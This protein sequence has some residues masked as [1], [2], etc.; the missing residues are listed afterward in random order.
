M[1]IISLA[2]KLLNPAASMYVNTSRNPMVLFQ[3]TSV[4]HIKVV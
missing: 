3:N 2:H 4:I 1:R